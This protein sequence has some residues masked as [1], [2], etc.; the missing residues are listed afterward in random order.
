MLGVG[1]GAIA[2]VIVQIAPSL[3]DRASG[4]LLNPLTVGGV[5]LGVAIMYVT[6]LLIS[7]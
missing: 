4:A 3:R 5:L 2:Q 7:V 1:A 6:G